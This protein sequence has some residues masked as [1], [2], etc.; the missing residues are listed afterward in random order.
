MTPENEASAL[1]RG[2]ADELDALRQWA[3]LY[4]RS[5]AEE[6][7]LAVRV[8]LRNHALG[9]VASERG[10]ADLKAQGENP[11]RE[12]REISE[13]LQRLAEVAY[14]PPPLSAP[15]AASRENAKT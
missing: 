5:L 2:P 1:Y 6:L 15:I 14:S 8:H 9:W 13:S 10:T 11:A 7:R 3:K 4:G 12:L